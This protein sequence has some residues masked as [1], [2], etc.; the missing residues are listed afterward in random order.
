MGLLASAAAAGQG[1]GAPREAHRRGL[2][3][4]ELLVVLAF[5]GVVVA[6]LLPAVQRVRRMRWSPE[7][8]RYGNRVVLFRNQAC[9]PCTLRSIYELRRTFL[10]AVPPH[11]QR[12][13]S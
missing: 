13:G 11:S 12:R 4:L 5:L 10:G 2:T 9:S 1:L 3:L 6:L 7:R 8:R